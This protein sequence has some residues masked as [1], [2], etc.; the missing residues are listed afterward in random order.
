LTVA[1]SSDAPFPARLI[2]A[3]WEA[4]YHTRN[5]RF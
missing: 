1:I 4:N 2:S 3:E 5:R